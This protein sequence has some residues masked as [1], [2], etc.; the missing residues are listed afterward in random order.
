MQ[1]APTHPLVTLVIS[2]HSPAASLRCPA[3]TATFLVHIIIEHSMELSNIST[4]TLCRSNRGQGFLCGQDV[5]SVFMGRIHVS[6]DRHLIF[7][8]RKQKL[9]IF[10]RITFM[11][12]PRPESW[13]GMPT[14][15]TSRAVILV[16]FIWPCTGSQVVV[17]FLRHWDKSNNRL[18][19]HVILT[20]LPVFIRYPLEL[21]RT[22]YNF[23]GRSS[24]V[25]IQLF[26]VD[27]LKTWT[28]SRAWLL[29]IFDAHWTS[30]RLRY[31][32]CLWPLRPPSNVFLLF[33]KI[34]SS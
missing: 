25:F 27:G 2:T 21:R 31:A 24:R 30:F 4:R 1:H 33:T 14:I 7:F 11:A 6:V 3:M 29:D 28:T 23:A 16:L 20:K 34:S 10:A 12:P 9:F 19:D 18:N 17:F 26:T 22:I 5:N 8:P 15:W 13:P 32:E